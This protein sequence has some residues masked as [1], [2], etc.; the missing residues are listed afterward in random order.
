MSWKHIDLGKRLF[1]KAALGTGGVALVAQAGG[2]VSSPALAQAAAAAGGGVDPN[3]VLAKVRREGRLRIGY[4][5]TSPW[6]Y[7]DARSGQL[8]GIYYDV[9]EE[10]CKLLE[11]KG[12]YAE[13]PWND[14]TV[15]LR[16]GDFD[17]FASSL[18][19]TV[20]RSV[21]VMFPAPTMWARGSL[22]LVHRDNIGKWK[23]AAELDS[24]DVTFSVNAGTSAEALVKQLFPKAKSI[25]TTGNI[26]T[27]AEPVRTKRAD[28]WINGENDIM[29]FAKRNAAWAAV[30]DEANPFGVSPNTWAIRYGDQP[31]AGFVSF[32]AQHMV[33]S[34]FVKQRYDHY[35][36][37]M[38]KG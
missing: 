19:Y 5:Q 26:L 28:V 10:L 20:P 4:G 11:V 37:L 14:A 36:D 32:W 16:R 7:K 30:L 6:F 8:M 2:G 33:S 24:P 25:S 15:A 1:F 23:S 38:L 21:A 34:G 29:V 13:V 35:M 9:A 17:L 3:S 27:A 22:A 31:W 12:E 18:T